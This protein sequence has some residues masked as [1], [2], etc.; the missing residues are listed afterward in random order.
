MFNGSAQPPKIDLV[1]SIANNNNYRTPMENTEN[2]QIYGKIIKDSK[3]TNI[4][5]R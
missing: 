4:E 2:G 1:M 3:I 5:E